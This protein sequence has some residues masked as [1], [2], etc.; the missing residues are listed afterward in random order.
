MSNWKYAFASVKGTS[1][2]KSGYPCQDASRCE[3]L[4]DRQGRDILVAVASDG[5]GSAP[6]SDQGSRLICS[7][8]VEEMR[9]FYA[10][11]GKTKEFTMSFIKDFLSYFQKEIASRAEEFGCTP[12]DFACTFLCA[13]I[14]KECEV[15][16]QIG[17]GAIVVS[18]ESDD[19]SWVFWPDQGEY[20]NTTYFATDAKAA[21][22]L[23][24]DFRQGAS[25]TEV[26]LFSDGLQKLA[27][28]YQS[29]SAHSPFFR[30]FFSVLRALEGTTSE[31]YTES[32]KSFLGSP[33]VNDRTDDDKTLILATR[34]GA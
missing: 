3:I 10:T 13:V 9:A 4:K 18:D 21:E 12:R 30:T 15:F 8:F 34:R 24:Y 26:A 32:L 19:Y 33:P 2:E 7:L 22:W 14:D 29:Q 28:H 31:K 23:R 5:A 1:H 25:C 11:G 6:N 27:L 16:A 20:E 17:D